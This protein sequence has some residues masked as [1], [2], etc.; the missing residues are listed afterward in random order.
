MKVYCSK[1]SL[2]TGVNTVQ[3]AVSSKNTLPVLQGIMIKAE[4]QSLIFEATD[5][6]IGIRC[7]VPA[8]VEEEGVAVLPSRIFSDL[9]RKLPDAAII[10]ELENDIITIKYYESDLSLRGY[11]PE[12]FP[13]LPDLLDAETFDLPVSLFKTMIK[14]TIF[15]CSTEESRPVFTGCLLQIEDN[16]IRLIATDTHRLAYR[17][18]E[19][20][21]TDQFKFQGIIPAKTLGEIYRLLREEDENLIIRFNP[22]QIVFQFGSVYLLSRLIE[23]QFPNYKQVIPQSC[24]TKV[25]LPTKLFQE[26]VERA[27]L[28]ARDGS[29]TSIIKL[30]IDTEHLSID[31]ASD[32]GKITE[33]MEIRKE[34]NDVKIAF[35]SKFLLDVLKII[36]SEEIIFELSGPYSPGIIR[37]VDDPDYLYLA[38]PVR[39]S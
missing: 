35:N 27:S 39:T 38:L 20:P 21:N 15:T 23:G 34:G 36:D 2:L 31:Q 26:S 19:I 11:D 14:Q 32:L 7:V 18:A 3:K 30:T 25:I 28:L 16:T 4:G 9:V 13:L 17:F 29:H 5:L 33:Q 6:E 12:E 24:Q 22:S 10:L 37:P 1:D 8:Q